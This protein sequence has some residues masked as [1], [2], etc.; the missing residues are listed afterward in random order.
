MYES[1]HDNVV[2]RVTSSVKVIIAV[3]GEAKTLYPGCQPGDS[4]TMV[5]VAAKFT[6]LISSRGRRV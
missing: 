4:G 5:A 3:K 2:L 1:I 6:I